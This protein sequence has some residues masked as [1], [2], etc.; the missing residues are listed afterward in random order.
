[1]NDSTVGTGVGAF[2]YA[3]GWETSTG[4]TTK[5]GGDDHYSGVGGTV[6]TLRFSGTGVTLVGSRAPWHG[7]AAVSIDGGPERVV[8]YYSATR[9]DQVRV[10]TSPVL[11]R[12]EHV[13]KVRVLGT[14]SA[15]STG[16][17]VTID[18]ADVSS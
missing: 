4:S 14:R 8:D 5:S 9:Q 18:R 10:F 13:L 17:V 2:D 6:A 1:M 16:D 12:G 7:R 11:A 3:A 15:T